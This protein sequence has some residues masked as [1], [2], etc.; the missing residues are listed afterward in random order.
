MTAEICRRW[1]DGLTITKVAQVVIDTFGE[2][3]E[4]QVRTVFDKLRR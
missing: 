2:A 4:Q 1:F 3:T